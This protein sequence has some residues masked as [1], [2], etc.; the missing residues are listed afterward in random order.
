MFFH[1]SPAHLIQR[2]VTE[3]FVILHPSSNPVINESLLCVFHR[4]AW[5]SHLNPAKIHVTGSHVKRTS[6]VFPL[7]HQLNGVSINIFSS[8]GPRRG[9]LSFFF[10]SPRKWPQNFPDLGHVTG[11]IVTQVQSHHSASSCRG[12]PTRWLSSLCTVNKYNA[13]RDYWTARTAFFSCCFLFFF[14]F[15]FDCFV[16]G[17]TR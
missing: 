17:H 1:S 8:S 14:F 12:A 15:F 6:Q 3:T 11:L 16:F 13:K 7:R 5:P 2:R 9:R 10:T 4:E